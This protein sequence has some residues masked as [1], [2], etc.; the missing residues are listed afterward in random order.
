LRACHCEPRFSAK[1]SIREA[2]PHTTGAQRVFSAVYNLV[3]IGFQYR[4]LI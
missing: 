4:M 2:I 1:Q 3:I